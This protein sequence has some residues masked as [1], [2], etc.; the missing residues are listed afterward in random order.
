VEI[1]AS[2]GD[3]QGIH[4]IVAIPYSG[5]EQ[6][7]KLI[8]EDFSSDID[9]VEFRDLPG[10]GARLMEVKISSLAKGATAKAILT[11]E[12]R[13]R[14]ILPPDE[15][16]TSELTSPAKPARELKAYLT[17]SPFI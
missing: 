17:P 13:T 12:I 9:S 6:Q 3:C 2:R 16:A 10:G 1:N 4:A 5:A 14:P 8:N 11:Y 7:V 15:K